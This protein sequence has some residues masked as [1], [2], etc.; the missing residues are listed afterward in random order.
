MNTKS[1]NNLDRSFTADFTHTVR[2]ALGDYKIN[3]LNPSHNVLFGSE[4]TI[5]VFKLAQQ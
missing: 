4:C 3:K 2:A 5:K 1:N